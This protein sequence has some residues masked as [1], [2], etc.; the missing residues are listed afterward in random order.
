MII[1]HNSSTWRD[2]SWKIQDSQTLHL[3]IS[4]VL[5]IC[6][7]CLFNWLL[8]FCLC[9]PGVGWHMLAIETR[10]LRWKTCANMC[11]KAMIAKGQNQKMS[12]VLWSKKHC[13]RHSPNLSWF[14]SAGYISD[15]LAPL[16]CF[17]LRNVGLTTSGLTFHS[18]LEQHLKVLQN[19][20]WITL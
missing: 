3:W 17:F 12:K 5:V 11:V 13:N 1:H 7:M 10:S 18:V 8:Y 14:F 9:L 6:I 19:G 20:S 16:T 2:I 15:L 4:E